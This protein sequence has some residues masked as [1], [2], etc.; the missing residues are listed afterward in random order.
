MPATRRRPV[1][2]EL[3]QRRPPLP[4]RPGEAVA[5]SRAAGTLA[6]GSASSSAAPPARSVQAAS[7]ASDAA[8]SRAR[9]TSSSPA[10]TRVEQR[11]RRRHPRRRIRARSRSRHVRA[12]RA[13]GCGRR[14]RSATNSFQRAS[15]S[16]RTT[17]AV[18]EACGAAPRAARVVTGVDVRAQLRLGGRLRVGGRGDDRD[19]LVQA[20]EDADERA[21]DDDVAGAGVQREPAQ[22]SGERRDEPDGQE[23][24][25]QQ[26]LGDREHRRRAQPPVAEQGRQVG[27]DLLHDVRRHAVQDDRDGD[28]ALDGLRAASAT[29]RCRCSGWRS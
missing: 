7:S 16:P 21:A 1:L 12:R 4:Q 18:D 2:D 8:R 24:V 29:G 25:L 15:T 19:P 14:R 27:A 20:V 13:P 22:P 10:C 9:T 6:P 5:R 26:R 28:A 17:A 11:L 3:G 23:A